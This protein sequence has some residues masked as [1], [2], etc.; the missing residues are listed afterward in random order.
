MI[1]TCGM[2]W[3]RRNTCNVTER[4]AND[5][6]IKEDKGIKSLVLSTRGH[7]TVDR[8]IGKKRPN[9][10]FAHVTR[11][12]FAVKK[13]EAMRPGHVHLF[14]TDTIVFRSNCIRNGL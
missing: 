10:R 13:D 7:V 9:F 6:R 3:H 12:F 11:V 1:I 8:Q 5:I 4:L 14:R 2:H